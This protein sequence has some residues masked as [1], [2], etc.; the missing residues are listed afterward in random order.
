M[1][2][3]IESCRQNLMETFECKIFLI[4][5]YHVLYFKHQIYKIKREFK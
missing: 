3:K 4:T 2:N 5:K 1:D